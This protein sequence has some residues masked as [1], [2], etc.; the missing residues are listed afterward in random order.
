MSATKLKTLTK[1]LTDD[2]LSAI[3]ALLPEAGKDQYT[4]SSAISQQMCKS[5]GVN[6]KLD[7]TGENIVEITGIT[8]T[9]YKTFAG[10]VSKRMTALTKANKLFRPHDLRTGRMNVYRLFAD[11][12]KNIAPLGKPEQRDIALAGSAAPSATPEQSNQVNN[13]KSQKKQSVG[14]LS[15]MQR[16]S[17]LLMELSPQEL[18]TATAEIVV[19]Q[20]NLYN[21]SQ[22][23]LAETSKELQANKEVVTK[24]KTAV[25]SI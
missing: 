18:G 23:K 17:K 14:K 6:I 3:A 24:L 8:E 16:F 21:E 9:E 25:A 13:Q 1:N 2:V 11:G 5:H 12:D 22:A 15:T 7:S 4:H 20:Q 10:K 19:R